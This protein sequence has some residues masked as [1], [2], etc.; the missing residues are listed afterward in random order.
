MLSR[1]VGR[2]VGNGAGAVMIV[3]MCAIPALIVYTVVHF[4]LKFW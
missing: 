4:I 3:G 2:I 1:K